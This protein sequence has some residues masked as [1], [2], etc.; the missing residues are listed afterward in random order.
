MASH[1]CHAIDC[2][3]TTQPRMFMCPRHWRMLPKIH[4]DAIWRNYVHGQERRKDPSPAY[5]EAAMAAIHALSEIEK[6]A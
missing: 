3:V 1:T 6:A 2:A 5:L 4:K